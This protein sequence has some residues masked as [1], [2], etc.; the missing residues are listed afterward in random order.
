MTRLN[1]ILDDSVYARLKAQVPP[2]RLSAFITEA[3]RARLR[4]SREELDKAYQEDAKD[5]ARI[6]LAND[7][8]CTELE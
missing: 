5:P 4:P 6:E 3:V 2:K 7:W 8:K 1:I